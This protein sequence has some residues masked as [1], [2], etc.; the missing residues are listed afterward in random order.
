[1]IYNQNATSLTIWADNYT[2]RKM[3]AGAEGVLKKFDLAQT[4]NTAPK[5]VPV[6]D[7]YFRAKSDAHG[8][9]E[10]QQGLDPYFQNL[11]RD[12]WPAPGQDLKLIS[13]E[14]YQS[15]NPFWIIMLTPIIVGFFG[16]LRARGKEPSTPTKIACGIIISG[17]S[18][19]I[20]I[21]ACLSTNI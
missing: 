4:V 11:P 8:H 21:V 14:L 9:I 13:T 6:L 10:T 7:K 5:D 12:Q 18:S 20:M 1:N 2:H 17:L 15:V 19:V 3:P 16:W